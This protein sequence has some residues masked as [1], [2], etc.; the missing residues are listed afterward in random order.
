MAKISPSIVR[1]KLAACPSGLIETWSGPKLWQSS[2]NSS[3]TKP[4]ANARNHRWDRPG[5]DGRVLPETK[6]SLPGAKPRGTRPVA[7]D[8]QH[9]QFEAVTPRAS[10]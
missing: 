10:E 7:T 6:Q 3:F 4:Y 8:Q 9:R 1:R 5:I 2:S